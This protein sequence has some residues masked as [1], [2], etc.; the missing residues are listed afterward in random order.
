MQCLGLDEVEIECQ[1]NRR[2]REAHAKLARDSVPQIAENKRILQRRAR[3][4][5]QVDVDAGALNGCTRERLRQMNSELEKEI[6]T[7]EDELMDTQEK[8]KR[9]LGRKRRLQKT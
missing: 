7:V 1:A 5:F 8:I 4:H 3:Q 2:A 6:R 9:L